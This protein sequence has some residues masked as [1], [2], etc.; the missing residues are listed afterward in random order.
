MAKNYQIINNEYFNTGGG[1]MVHITDVY[2]TQSKTMRYVFINEEYLVVAS[3]DYVRNELPDGMDCEDFMM[4][5]VELQHFTN[6]P[7]F[8]T[9]HMFELPEEITDL[10]FDCW[11][12]YIRAYCKH[13]GKNLA[14]RL[15]ALPSELYDQVTREYSHWL[16]EN[17]LDPVTDGYRV[18]IHPEYIAAIEDETLNSTAAYELQQHL[19]ECMPPDDLDANHILWEKFYNEKLQIIYCGK[20]FTFDNGADTYNGLDEFAKFIISQQ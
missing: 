2:D 3:Y 15:D 1:C 11:L 7:S 17:E 12:L 16:A 5:S 10:L 13:T 8:D 4:H 20:L 14:C 19:K 9:Y 18:I 6:E